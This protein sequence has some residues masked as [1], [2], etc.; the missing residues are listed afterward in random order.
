LFLL[1]QFPLRRFRFAALLLFALVVLSP[2]AIIAAAHGEPLAR[3]NGIHITVSAS[4]PRLVKICLAGPPAQEPIVDSTR[5]LL[6]FDLSQSNHF[7]LVRVKPPLVTM[8]RS[9]A[10]GALDA[11]ESKASV[12]V[13]VVWDAGSAGNSFTFNGQVKDSRTLRKILSRTFSVPMEQQ[14]AVLHQFVDEVALM[15]SGSSGTA[16]CKI[17]F[18]SDC[19]GHKELYTADYDGHNVRQLTA[20]GRIVLSPAYSPQGDKIAFIRFKDNGTVLSILDV[21]SGAIIDVLSPEEI[22]ASPAWSPDGK[23]IAVSISVH[24][25]SDL[26]LF[27]VGSGT[28]TRLTYEKSIETSPTFAPN[29]RSIAFTSD[30]TGR[31]QIYVMNID[32]SGLRR[33]TFEGRHNESPAWSPDGSLIAYAALK[34]NAFELRLIGPDGDGPYTVVEELSDGESPAW[35][36]DGQKLIFSARD[37]GTFSALYLVNRDG[38]GLTKVV[39]IVGNCS[40]PSWSP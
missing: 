11:A 8:I 3:D 24:G 12:D 6:E 40:E 29:G 26:Y 1:G 30:R 14:R 27:D 17:A 31:P 15:L 13:F 37:E 38:S 5:E 32:G 22:A 20:L 25:N 33:L 7:E 10:A 16:H 18:V 21:A 4:G 28:L 39:S 34:G 19:T 35:S 36:P 2:P 9:G 23:L